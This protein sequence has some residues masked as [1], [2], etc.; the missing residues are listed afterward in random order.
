MALPVAGCPL[1]DQ[2]GGRLVFQGA[3]L[4]VIHAAETGFPAFYRVVWSDHV[5]EWSDLA[6]EDRALCMEAVAVVCLAFPVQPPQRSATWCRTC[7]GT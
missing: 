3:K 7:I 4:R 2:A 5:A 1:C 6:P